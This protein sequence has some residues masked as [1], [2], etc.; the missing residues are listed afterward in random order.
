MY[1]YQQNLNYVN[2]LASCTRKKKEYLEDWLSN[3]AVLFLMNGIDFYKKHPMLCPFVGKEYHSHKKI[4]LIGESHFLPEQ[5]SCFLTK[6]EECA[7]IWYHG[8][9][10][11][12]QLDRKEYGFSQEDITYMWT[13][14]VVYAYLCG[15]HAKGTARMFGIPWKTMQ[16]CASVRKEFMLEDECE[17]REIAKH[18]AFMNYF[19][20]PASMSGCSIKSIAEDELA[21]YENLKQVMRILE[22]DHMFFLSTL[23]GNSFIEHAKKDACFLDN[24]LDER[25]TVLHHPSTPF[26]WNKPTNKFALNK[27]ALH[28]IY[29]EELGERKPFALANRKQ[30]NATHEYLATS[31]EF[32]LYH[33]HQ[34]FSSKA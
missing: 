34:L 5:S 29:K 27:E 9:F 1:E 7:S 19:I 12:E 15:Q 26:T 33:L 3:T 6:D 16:A 28:C 32:F 13:I 14:H 25:I 20:R 18:I 31:E 17:S 22:P 10:S 21:A 4:M 23:A 11:W 30:A 24:L 2:S 8:D